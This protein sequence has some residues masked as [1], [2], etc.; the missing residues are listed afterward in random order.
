[1]RII[2]KII[3]RTA[4]LTAII[5]LALTIY[6]QKKH[7]YY[8]IGYQLNNGGISGNISMETGSLFPDQIAIDSFLLAQN[9]GTNNPVLLSIYQFPDKK[10]FDYFFSRVNKK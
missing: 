7:N 6:A 1:M 9:P 3:M 10:T 5:L 4:L 2:Y 8:L